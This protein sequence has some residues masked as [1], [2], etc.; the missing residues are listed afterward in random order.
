[1]KSVTTFSKSNRN[2][3]LTIDLV[4][5]LASCMTTDKTM[6]IKT[7][8]CLDR[9][10]T[11]IKN[12]QDIIYG[13]KTLVLSPANYRQYG[14]II[15]SVKKLINNIAGNTIGLDFINAVLALVEDARIGCQR[16]KNLTLQREWG[17]LNQ[18]LATLYGHVD[19]DLDQYN[20]MQLG[21][22]LAGRFKKIMVG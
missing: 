12:I 2:L 9:I 3:I 19:P 18:S 22:N 16:S 7:R 6:P 11:R 10:R 13:G 4:I 15:S 21:D 17:H 14:R 8:R 5:A 20:L 1:M